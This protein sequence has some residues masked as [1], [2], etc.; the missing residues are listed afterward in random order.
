MFP[1]RSHVND[2]PGKA[3]IVDGISRYLWGRQSAWRRRLS[4]SRCWARLGPSAGAPGGDQT[5]DAADQG[6]AAER[7]STELARL[8]GE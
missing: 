8:P 1:N 6:N 3:R 7:C 2:T 5:P 4:G